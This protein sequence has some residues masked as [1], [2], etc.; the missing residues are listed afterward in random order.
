M[1]GGAERKSYAQSGLFSAID[2][3]LQP[4]RL[5]PRRAMGARGNGGGHEVRDNCVDGWRDG[6]GWRNGLSRRCLAESAGIDG[7]RARQQLHE[8]VSRRSRSRS[9]AGDR[10]LSRLWPRSRVDV[11]AVA[12]QKGRAHGAGHDR[13]PARHCHARDGRKGRPRGQSAPPTPLASRWAERPSLMA[14]SPT[15]S[16][17]MSPNSLRYQTSVARVARACHGARGRP[18]PARGQQPCRHRRDATGLDPRDNR[19]ET[20]TTSEVQTIRRRFAASA[21]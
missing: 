17:T 8:A 7:D 13:R 12:A 1:S 10:R 14:G 2:R 5:L 21:R 6:R 15:C 18:P 20:F 4:F 11:R 9:S 16:V 3:F 19:P